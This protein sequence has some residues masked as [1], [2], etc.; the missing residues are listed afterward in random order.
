MRVV[1]LQS[2]YLPWKGY[3]DLVHEADRFVF[4]DDVQYTKNDWRNRNRLYGANGLFWLT[5]PVPKGPRDR[6]I[7]EVELADDRWQ[8]KHYRALT[9]TYGAAPFFEQLEPLLRETYFDRRWH[10][11]IDV[12]RHL[13][14]AIA[15]RLGSRTEFYDS[16]DLLDGVVDDRIE[17]LLVQL[18][19][20]DA[21]EYLS[22]PAARAY[23]EG[24]EHR[25]GD[26]GIR[27]TFKRYD[28]Y[29]AYPQR[30]E[31]FEPGVSIV[32]L[33][34]HVGFDEAPWYIWGHRDAASPRPAS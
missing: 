27:L 25:F 3:F 18:R 13:V 21:T 4:Y 26:E 23:L 6:Q 7:R 28:D 10:R 15:R 22:G 24:S 12:D 8:L 5:V 14:R 33:L 30:R 16:H 34:A 2:N 19:R 31:P 32:D 9:T 11:L 17:R 29:P 20:L 1:I